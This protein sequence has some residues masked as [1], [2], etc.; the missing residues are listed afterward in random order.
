MRN[1]K[2]LFNAKFVDLFIQNVNELA[3]YGDGNGLTREDKLLTLS[4]CN[5]YTEDGRLFV[6]AKRVE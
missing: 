3:V 5:S 1:N 4:T 6:V 2:T